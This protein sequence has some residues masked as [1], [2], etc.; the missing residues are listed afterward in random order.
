ML[1]IPAWAVITLVGMVLVWGLECR[2]RQQ[3]KERAWQQRADSSLGAARRAYQD[4]VNKVN[5]QLLEQYSARRDAEAR[6]VDA[7]GRARRTR[8]RV[9]T[10]RLAFQGD[11]TVRDSLSTALEVI[12]AQDTALARQQAVV[13]GL[14]DLVR[15]D[16]G[17]R[18][19]FE[20]RMAADSQRIASLEGVLRARPR[21][22]RFLGVALPEVRCGIGLG[23]GLSLSGTPTGGPIGGC[24]LTLR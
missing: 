10:V 19:L 24:L 14:T 2:G 18:R 1:K 6:T 17:I 22:P 7:E 16:S 20:L 23:V 8:A 12:E 3:E 13:V 9:D 4:T 11:S 5:R 21:G 15:A